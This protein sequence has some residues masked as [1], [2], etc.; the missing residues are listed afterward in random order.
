MAIKKLRPMTP[1]QR[2]MSK[3]TFEE[4]TTDRAHKPLLLPMSSTA[5]RNNTGR[6]TARH[7]G[8]G[9][10]K[11][12]RIIDF[13]RN[14]LNVAGK[15]A[16]IEYDPNRNARIALIFYVDGEKRYILAP[17]GLEVGMQIIASPEADIKVG[18]AMP[19][20]NIPLGTTIHNIELRQGKGGQIVRSAGAM[21]QLV[22]KEGEYGQVKL[23]SGEQRMVHLNCIATIG[24]V[25]NIEHK[26]MSIGKA[27]RKRWMGV[28]PANRGVTMNACDHPHG[29]GEGKSPIGGKPQ[30]PWGKPAMG[31][32][33]RRNKTTSRF[34]V[35]ERSR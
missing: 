25:G 12:Y 15:V 27:G 7:K 6:V 22:A 30:T 35:R 26:N 16:T 24:Q 33:T 21:A 11:H 2:G 17:N 31:F 4:L 23:P 32:K 5:G 18:N 34:I 29:G 1:G 20:R 28:R 14:K 13:K 10:K 9:H 3:S 19:L 8:G